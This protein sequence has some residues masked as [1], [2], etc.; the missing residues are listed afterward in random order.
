MEKGVKS[1]VSVPVTYLRCQYSE[2]VRTEGKQNRWRDIVAVVPTA[3][4][5][6]NM[7]SI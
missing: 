5:E 6:G 4:H 3:Q 1:M 7:S 2:V